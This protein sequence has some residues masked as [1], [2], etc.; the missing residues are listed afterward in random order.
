MTVSSEFPA[1]VDPKSGQRLQECGGVLMAGDARYPVV[2]GIP[3]ILP[4]AGSYVDAFGEQWNRWQR[5]QLDSLTGVP[6]SRTRLLRC[7][8]G[9]LARTMSTPGGAVDVLEAGCGAGRFTEVLLGLPAVRLTSVDLS[10]A[11]EANERN[12]PQDARHCI[13]QCDICELPFEQGS[14]DVVVCLGVIQHTPD[15]ERTIASLYSRVKPG[16]W[17]VIDH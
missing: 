4:D 6:I 16:G 1:L 14:F 10:T 15:P 11:V 13:V 3:R 17:L 12:F 2:N 7:I 9:D 5:T 8:G